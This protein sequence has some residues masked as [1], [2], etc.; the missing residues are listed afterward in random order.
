MK[1]SQLVKFGMASVVMACA[2]SVH[3]DVTG[4]V[5]DADSNPVRGCVITLL[6]PSD[7]AFVASDITDASG[8]FRVQ[9]PS[10]R[11]LVNATALGHKPQNLVYDGGELTV[12]LEA[13]AS[14]LGEVTVTAAA[15]GALTRE[16]DRYVYLPD[17][18][19][20]EVM[21]A[22]DVLKTVPLVTAGDNAVEILGKGSSLLYINGKPPRMGQ[23]AAFAMLATV[24]PKDIKRVEII[25]N[26][27]NMVGPG[28]QGGIVNVIMSEPDQ[29]LV[30]SARAAWR[31]SSN[32]ARGNVT[33]PSVYLGY[34]HDKFN[35]ALS[36]GYS[37]INTDAHS[38]SLYDYKKDGYQ[39][40]NDSHC[41]LI[42]NSL[43]LGM[44]ATYDFTPVSKLG[45]TFATSASGYRQRTSAESLDSREPE[46]VRFSQLSR[47]PFTRPFF[48]GM[49]FYTLQ[50]DDNGSGI[51]AS[52]WYASNKEKRDTEYTENGILTASE[53]Y[54]NESEVAHAEADYTHY[55]LQGGSLS[56]GFR[57]NYARTDRRE[58]RSDV[59]D[60][61]LYDDYTA[62]IYAD[63]RRKWS[64]VFSMAVGLSGEYD[65]AKG[66][67]RS[68]SQT[69]RRN[70]WNLSPNA[71][72]SFS[73][74]RASQ[75][76]AL[77]Y[78]QYVSRPGVRDMNPFR[79]ETSPSTYT[80]GNPALKNSRTYMLSLRYS[81]LNKIHAV[82]RL[83]KNDNMT[84]DY[85]FTDG[86]GKTV[87]TIGNF[88]DSRSF[89][90]EAGYYDT[91]AKFMRLSATV[92]LHYDNVHAWADG[93]NIG[94]SGWNVR[95]STS[96][97][98]IIAPWNFKV[99]I[100]NALMGPSKSVTQK[101]KTRDFL[102]VSLTKYL[103]NAVSLSLDI[104]NITNNRTAVS[105]SN[106]DYGYS[107]RPENLGV[108]F[109]VKVSYVF[110][111]RRVNAIAERSQS[112][113]SEIAPGGR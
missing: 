49:A 60:S 41:V 34:A 81:L 29:G 17:A 83:V 30:G 51:D 100:S 46:A 11:Y 74:P 110:G 67:Q 25:T 73:L 92:N 91:F 20:G 112:A 3:A 37:Y 61:F 95:Q 50:T 5:R 66:V 36:A 38:R 68:L 108:S 28:F 70:D 62:E 85:T 12:V 4:Q 57:L 98:F 106:A 102:D 31:S 44:T 27:G 79:I 1:Q 63:Y 101:Y 96:L 9:A 75:S 8:R 111:K 52:A 53:S 45:V 94:Y 6:A 82:A 32:D 24:P 84:S 56:A 93:S 103:S 90:F 72:I 58:T 39:V 18:L 71:S 99:D 47:E 104:R 35:A 59:E 86:E 105:Y 33:M 64:N 76:L 113:G 89:L 2:A 14:D 54:V 55:F 88:G 10:G 16:A 109:E 23:N 80:T 7:S 65:H 15:P 40:E 22:K 42:G 19:P 26:P 107:I 97:T 87:T 13:I 48:S 21:T 77:E 69:F 78:S 43:S